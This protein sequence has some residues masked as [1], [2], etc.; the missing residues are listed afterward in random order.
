MDCKIMYCIYFCIHSVTEKIVMFDVLM[1]EKDWMK[2]YNIYIHMLS[3][4]KIPPTHSNTHTHMHAHACLY[5]NTINHTIS[6]ISQT[7]YCDIATHRD[8]IISQWQGKIACKVILWSTHTVK[9][10]YAWS[11]SDVRH[12]LKRIFIFLFI[13]LSF[14]LCPWFFF[15]LWC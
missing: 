13:T 10:T 2:M 3:Q 8:Y 7:Q 12:C 15:W 1:I 5:S 14:L 4:V 11:R 6:A 9:Q